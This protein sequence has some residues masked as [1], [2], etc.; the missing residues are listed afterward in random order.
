MFSFFKN[1]E[2]IKQL[3]DK[4]KTLEQQLTTIKHQAPRIEEI[5][6]FLN[7]LDRLHGAVL[8]VTRV[9]PTEIY[10]WNGSGRE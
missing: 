7:D 8:Q 4:I 1:K 9:N 3:E 6:H 10:R 5:S 2:K